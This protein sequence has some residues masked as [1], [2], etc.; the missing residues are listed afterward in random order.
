MPL[1]RRGLIALK[2]GYIPA[3]EIVVS[4][5]DLEAAVGSHAPFVG[6]FGVLESV[7]ILTRR[8]VIAGHSQLEDAIA[9]IEID[10]V[11][12]RALSIRTLADYRGP[13]VVLEA[14]ATIS[15]AEAEFWLIITTMG[16][17]SNGLTFLRLI[18]SGLSVSAL[19]TDD[20]ALVQK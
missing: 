3:N 20:L 11:L 4:E 19:G 16:I 1:G 9:A 7:D 14:A 13:F 18:L 15:E 8:T 17:P 12:D 6:G 10:D 2:P 5:L